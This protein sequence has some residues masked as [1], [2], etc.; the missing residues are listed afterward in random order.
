[1]NLGTR[2]FELNTT[3]EIRARLGHDR[4]VLVPAIKLLPREDA[5]RERVPL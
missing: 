3:Y 5:A 4:E 2:S 1:M